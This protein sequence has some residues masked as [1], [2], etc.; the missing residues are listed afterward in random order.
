MMMGVRMRRLSLDLLRPCRLRVALESG[1]AVFR[2]MGW[3]RRIFALSNLFVV[4][5]IFIMFAA[6]L[7][8]VIMRSRETTEMQLVNLISKYELVL[9]YPVLRDEIVDLSLASPEKIVTSENLMP[10][11]YWRFRKPVRT[12]GLKYELAENMDPFTRYSPLRDTFFVTEEFF[13]FTPSTMLFPTG[14]N[15]SINLQ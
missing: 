3:L 6:N 7:I 1:L 12:D 9:G 4:A 8:N 13:I 2:R 5:I 14:K 15:L 10:T 11:L